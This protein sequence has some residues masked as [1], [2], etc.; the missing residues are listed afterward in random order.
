MNILSMSK[1]DCNNISNHLPKSKSLA[2]FAQSFSVVQ[3]NETAAPPAFEVPQSSGICLILGKDGL[4]MK[5]PQKVV[6]NEFQQ[7]VNCLGE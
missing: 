2:L 7:S 3:A 5:L 1:V 6:R 4:Q